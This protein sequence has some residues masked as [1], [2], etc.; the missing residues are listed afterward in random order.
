MSSTIPSGLRKLSLRRALWRTRLAAKALYDDTTLSGD[1]RHATELLRASV[2]QQIKA[3][4]MPDLPGFFTVSDEW[5]AQ[6][7]QRDP[8]I[9][10]AHTAQEVREALLSE[11]SADILATRRA[12]LKADEL[13]RLSTVRPPGRTVFVES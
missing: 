8:G 12:R 13:R 2:K 6:V 5:R 9:I 10:S 3:S 7:L 4:P 11:E 1:E